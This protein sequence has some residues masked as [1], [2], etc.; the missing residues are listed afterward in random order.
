MEERLANLEDTISDLKASKVVLPEPHFPVPNAQERPSPLRP[1]TPSQGLS[2]SVFN[3]IDPASR[4]AQPQSTFEVVVDTRGPAVI[5]ASVVSE[6]SSPPVQYIQPGVPGISRYG[7]DLI[8]KGKL[9][10]STRELIVA[11]SSIRCR[12]L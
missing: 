3:T 4:Q 11:C 2:P 9:S 1:D 12:E 7:G 10:A 5:P 8:T 6:L